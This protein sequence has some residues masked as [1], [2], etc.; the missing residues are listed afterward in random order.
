[1]TESETRTV[2][3]E[4]RDGS[5]AYDI[6]QEDYPLV[7]VV[8]SNVGT[9]D[10]LPEPKRDIITNNNAN[11]AVGFSLDTK[12]VEVQF[13]DPGS[14]NRKTFT[15]PETRIAVPRLH[16]GDY[17]MQLPEYIRYRSLW[18]FVV[19]AIRE[20]ESDDG[21]ELVKP[22]LDLAE[23]TPMF[24]GV[25]EPVINDLDIV[26]EPDPDDEDSMMLEL[27]SDDSDDT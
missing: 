24:A 13:L 7:I 21:S 11:Q 10:D 8:D 18:E 12:C 16:I 17:G 3:N 26:F 5:I 9:V 25:F 20:D 6:G 27:P 19:E 15:Y 14:S 1:M 23:R 2:K 4:I 22:I